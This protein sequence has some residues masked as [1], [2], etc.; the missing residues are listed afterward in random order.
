MSR[1]TRHLLTV[2]GALAAFTCWSTAARAGM[3]QVRAELFADI[4]AWS[5]DGEPSWLDGGLGKGRWGGHP[6][7]A[8]RS[9]LTLAELSALIDVELGWTTAAFVHLQYGEQQDEPVDLVEAFV[10]WKPVPRSALS[11]DLKAGLYFPHISREHTG[12]AWTTPYTITA[13]AANSW[14]GEEIRALGAQLGLTWRGETTTWRFTGGLFGFNDPAG[15]LL[16]YRG[17]GVGDVKVGAFSRLPLAPLPAIGP[18]GGFIPWQP[19]WVHPVRE[20]DGRVGYH[21]GLEGELGERLAA[22][23]FYYD[24][25]GDPAAYDYEQYA[26]DTRFYNFWAEY[27]PI[28]GLELL[29]QYMPGVTYMGRKPD[30]ENVAVDVHYETAFLLAR[31][32]T[33]PWHFSARAESFAVEDETYLVEDDNSEDG[34]AFCFAVAR[35]FGPRDRVLVEILRLDSERPARATIGYDPQQDQT[36]VQAAYRKRF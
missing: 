2:V 11:W 36:I 35:D 32:G 31:Y 16:A 8:S 33:G 14:V 6:D 5:A 4:R 22:G 27:R 20:I 26:W 25:G 1:P 7:G 29:A 28:P 30:G 12:P 34:K 23:A 19:H 17:W 9:A 24:N 21:V 10:T 15:T 3:P 18:G 13:A